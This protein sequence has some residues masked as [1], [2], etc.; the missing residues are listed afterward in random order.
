MLLGNCL[1][2][3]GLKHRFSQAIISDCFL[4]VLLTIKFSQGLKY[5]ICKKIW[6]TKISANAKKLKKSKF[7][8]MQIWKL[9]NL[10]N[11]KNEFFDYFAKVF[12]CVHQKLAKILKKNSVK[13]N[14]F[15]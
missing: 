12:V 5:L 11:L 2:R 14:Y 4:I 1:E 8:K 7:S 3:K 15:L 9:K 6:N 10:I 13:K